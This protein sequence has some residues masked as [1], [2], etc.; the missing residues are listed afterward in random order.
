MTQPVQT[1]DIGTAPSRPDQNE[2]LLGKTAL[3]RLEPLSTLERSVQVE[4][5]FNNEVRQS[6]RQNIEKYYLDLVSEL[7]YYVSF[8]VED[9]HIL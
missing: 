9:S 2:C 7:S 4:A 3:F 8:C 5:K 1:L 6:C